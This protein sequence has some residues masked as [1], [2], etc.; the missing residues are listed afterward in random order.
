MSLAFT[1]FS[2]FQLLPPSF[3]VPKEDE[4]KTALVLTL[5]FSATDIARTED[6]KGI[7]N[8]YYRSV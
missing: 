3:T 4:A 1:G 2:N 7:F 6:G 5:T 8:W